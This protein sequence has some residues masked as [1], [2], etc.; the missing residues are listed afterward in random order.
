VDRKKIPTDWRKRLTL[1]QARTAVAYKT[2]PTTLTTKVR[3]GGAFV[4]ALLGCSD[5]MGMWRHS[6]LAPRHP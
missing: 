5:G 6:L 3:P 2:L 1:V 4:D